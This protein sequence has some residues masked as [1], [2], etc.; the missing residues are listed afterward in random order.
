MAKR[1]ETRLLANNMLEVE[2]AHCGALLHLEVSQEET[3]EC[4]FC[5]FLCEFLIDAEQEEVLTSS[6]WN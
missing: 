5:E 4:P 6:R 2:C 3:H 1:R